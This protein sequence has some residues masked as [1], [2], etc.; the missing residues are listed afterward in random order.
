MRYKIDKAEDYLRRRLR[1][2]RDHHAANKEYLSVSAYHEK[3][4]AKFEQDLSLSGKLFSQKMKQKSLIDPSRAADASLVDLQNPERSVSYV[5]SSVLENPSILERHIEWDDSN[6][7]KETTKEVLDNEEQEYLSIPKEEVLIDIKEPMIE[8]VETPSPKKFFVEKW[9]KKCEKIALKGAVYGELE[10]IDSKY[11]SFSPSEEARS[12]E[13][14]YCLG[15][16]VIKEI[17]LYY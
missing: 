11:I 10:I 3:F 8:N 16:L 17:K 1:L 12:S 6:I 9:K 13:E 7:K 15:A 14:P 4:K 5:E 2:K